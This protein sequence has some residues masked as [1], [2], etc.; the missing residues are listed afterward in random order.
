MRPP[1]A[2][3]AG[4]SS[5]PRRAVSSCFIP[6]HPT[7]AARVCLCP[8]PACR[9]VCPPSVQPMPMGLKDLPPPLPPP[10]CPRQICHE[11]CRTRVTSFTMVIHT[12]GLS[13]YMSTTRLMKERPTL[14][15]RRPAAVQFLH[16]GR[17][18]F[19]SS[20]ESVI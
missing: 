17:P 2:G 16:V 12:T 18:R 4:L 15:F 1:P 19:T 13:T 8:P 20:L 9:S 7:A 14:P 5:A 10:S 11:T 3:P 6:R